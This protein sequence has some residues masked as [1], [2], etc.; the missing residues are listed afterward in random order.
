MVTWYFFVSI[1]ASNL[2]Y[3]YF[4]VRLFRVSMCVALL[5]YHFGQNSAGTHPC[6]TR[7]NHCQLLWLRLLYRLTYIDVIWNSVQFRTC[8]TGLD[9]VCGSICNAHCLPLNYDF[10]EFSNQQIFVSR[11]SLREEAHSVANFWG[12]KL[13]TRSLP[14]HSQQTLPVVFADGQYESE[15]GQHSKWNWI[16][17]ENE[18]ESCSVVA[19][20]TL[21]GTGNI[22]RKLT[23]NGH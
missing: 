8:I 21:T 6:F 17:K 11:C 2:L 19:Q 23:Q 15:T 16:A 9:K 7:Y 3:A 14:L 13:E 10:N 5:V 18:N 20:G 22:I 1:Y 4:R 12:H